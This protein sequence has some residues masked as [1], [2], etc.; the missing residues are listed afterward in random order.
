MKNILIGT[1]DNEVIRIIRN[2]LSSKYKIDTALNK[3]ECLKV[4]QHKEYDYLF[5]DITFLQNETA[6]DYKKE[7]QEYW[8]IFTDTE[9][10][11]MV[12]QEKIREAVNV[13][14]AGASNY[15]TYPLHKEE[16]AFVI[17]NSDEQIRV[18]SELDYFRNLSWRADSNAVLRTNSPL[19]HE[20]YSKVRAVSQTETTVLLTGETGTGKS[21]IA[22]LIHQHSRR[23]DK[24]FISLHCGAL[25]DSLLESELFGHEKGAFTGAVRRKMGKFE[26]ANS[27]T[28]FLD[29]IGT[30]SATM[31]IKLLQIIQEKTYE[32]VGGE[33]TLKA[34]VRIIAATNTDLDKMC[35]AGKFRRDLFYRLNVFPIEIPPLRE[36]I[37][38]IPIFVEHF[39]KKLNKLA[40]K[41]ISAVHPE[42]LEAFYAYEWPGNIR[43]LENLFER[44]Y[45]LE[46][47]SILTPKSFP[48]ML[49]KEKA[50]KFIAMVDTSLTL[51]EIRKKEIERI[52]MQY[53]EQLL[54][55]HHGKINDT[56]KAAGVGVRQ[57]HKLL[58][59]YN[60]HKE[61]FKDSQ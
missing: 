53:L 48:L 26:I 51:E 60:L 5:I 59:R 50:K 10:F 43:E 17:K 29:E 11:V 23:S 45:I 54:K 30:I 40:A 49:F 14:K 8:Q 18:Y 25:P 21:I 61:D 13:V 35:E 2:S 44:A 27:G 36:R 4:F 22:K 46:T 24:Q 41:N 34:D 19:M 33:S 56:A 57:L 32:R 6:C 1:S 20:I 12:S 47:S 7:L 15:L 38:D 9:F 31:Q 37:E 58:T 28:I 16:I 3:E 42:V 39:L 52:E 55:K